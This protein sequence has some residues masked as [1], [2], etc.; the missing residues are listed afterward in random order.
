MT[1]LSQPSKDGKSK[2]INAWQHL[3]VPASIQA[4]IGSAVDQ[5]GWL[6]F[7]DMYV[8]CEHC[9]VPVNNDLPSVDIKCLN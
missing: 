6:L 3:W 9:I 7:H 2:E 5:E 8:F 4:H 1:S